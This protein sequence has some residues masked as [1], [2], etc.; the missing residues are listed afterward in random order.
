MLLGYN[1][2]VYPICI[3]LLIYRAYP[4]FSA[5]AQYD[6]S[7][8]RK[9]IASLPVWIVSLGAVG[10]LPGALLFPLGIDLLAGPLAI[11]TYGHFAIDFVL[12]ALIAITYAYFGAEAILLRVLYP[13]FLVG[14]PHPR[15]TAAQELRGVPRRMQLAQIVAAIIPLLAAILIVLIEPAEPKQFAMFRFL[16][17]VLITLGMF[18]FSFSMT[19]VRVLQRTYQ[20]LT[21][22]LPPPISERW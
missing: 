14:Q 8:R 21:G 9:R 2:V 19:T 20:A 22:A 3:G 12:S 16:V 11:S 17:T 5:S 13:R 7:E 6:S 1:L 10:W 15:R 4:I 18:G